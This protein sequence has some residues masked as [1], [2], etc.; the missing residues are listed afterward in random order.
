MRRNLAVAA[1]FVLILCVP[2]VSQA[3]PSCYGAPN[4]A[5]TRGSNNGILFMLGI[6]GFVQVGFIAL[7]WSFWRKAKE[8]RERFQVID[9]GRLTP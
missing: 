6:V 4:S 2:A 1:L 8:R 5:M 3:C 9:G 7:F